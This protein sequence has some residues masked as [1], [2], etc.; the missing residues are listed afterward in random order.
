MRC[1]EPLV[2]AL[3]LLVVTGCSAGDGL[4]DDERALDGAVSVC[5]G[6]PP[7]G[8]DLGSVALVQLLSRDRVLDSVQLTVPGEVVL[9][10]PADAP[11]TRLV[12]DGELWGGSPIGGGWGVSRGTGCPTRLS[13]PR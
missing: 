1:R 13:G 3:S 9:R 11:D 12:V 10:T 8:Q 4:S 7:Q 6:A 5:V 2:A